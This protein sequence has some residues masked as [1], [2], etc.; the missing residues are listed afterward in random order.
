MKTPIGDG[1]RNVVEKLKEAP[2]SRISCRSLVRVIYASAPTA[3]A[4][5]WLVHV[6]YRF[7]T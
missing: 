1:K 2:V 3:R 7:F 6:A 5:K 4:G